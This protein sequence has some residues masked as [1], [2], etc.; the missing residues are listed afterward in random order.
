MR[1]FPFRQHG[2][3]LRDVTYLQTTVSIQ[4]C[5][6]GLLRVYNAG[7]FI[8]GRRISEISS[9]GKRGCATVAFLR[10]RQPIE[11]V[12]GS[13]RKRRDGLSA[14]ADST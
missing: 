11:G 1:P 2:V 12:C 6:Q 10:W 13:V 14:G 5:L 7:F 9:A 8:L 4:K 3:L